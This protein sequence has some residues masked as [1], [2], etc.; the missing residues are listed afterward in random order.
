MDKL[1]RP[2]QY[3]SVWTSVVLVM[4]W[5][6]LPASAAEPKLP[7]EALIQEA[8]DRNPEIMASR[9]RWEAAKAVPSQ[10]ESLPDPILAFAYRGRRR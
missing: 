5:S 10:A 2:T 6:V 9:E 7:L 1:Y 4:I 3:V 8:L